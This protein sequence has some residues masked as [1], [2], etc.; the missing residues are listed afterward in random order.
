MPRKRERTTAKVAWTEEDLLHARTA[1]ESGMSK[2]LAARTYKIPF[3][4]LRD[5]LK[6]Q[7]IGRPRL[8]RKPVF[9]QQQESEIAEQVKLL[10]SIYYGLSVTDLRKS[11]YKYAEINSIKN[12]FDKNSKMAGLDWVQGFMRRN[13]SVAVRKAEA[14]SLNRVSAF[15]KEEITH[16]YQMLGDLMEKYRFPPNNIYNADKTGITT[17]TDPGKVLAE[18]G[19]R[20]VGAVT[21]GESGRNISV[22]CAMS[23]AG[24]FVPPMFIF[25]RQ[26]MTPLLEKDG[27]PGAFYTHSKNGWINEE[28]FV[29]WLKHFAAYVKPTE[30]SPVLVILD[31]HSSHISLPAFNYCKKNHIAMLSIP[32]HS[33]HR[34]QPLDVS[35]Y[36][37]LKAAYRHECN[38]HMKTHLM[39]KITPYDVACLFNKAYAQVANI[40]KGEAGFRATGIYPLNPN[41]FTEQDF[42]PASLMAQNSEQPTQNENETGD[43]LGA[44]QTHHMTINQAPASP[45]TGSSLDMSNHQDHESP[46]PDPLM[47]A[48]NQNLE[49]SVHAASKSQSIKNKSPNSGPSNQAL[50][51]E[52]KQTYVSFSKIVTTPP[53][54]ASTLKPAQRKRK[55]HS[56]I[57]T[58]T[59]MKNIL[60]EKETNKKKKLNK[61]GRK[62]Q[63]RSKVTGNNRNK[64]KSGTSCKRKVLQDSSSDDD[65]QIENVCDDDSD[66]ELSVEG[67]E[68]NKCNI[69]EEF[70]RN[71]EMWYRCTIC[72]FWTHAMC[73]GWDSPDGYICDFC[74]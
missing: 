21:S 58:S 49:A 47:E 6:N 24:N 73:T 19:Q 4:T 9:N 38:M 63:T 32:P 16:F 22:M 62:D 10:G 14:T 18:K 66:D 3:T 31:N 1:I 35:F 50:L 59:P 12:N 39:A 48:P 33:S 27:P 20:R 17:V 23:A 61:T 11:V 25:L 41:V 71:N 55:Q 5:R 54:I 40:S 15:N 7:N 53:T 56:T 67:N 34:T 57:L 68:Y 72:G 65:E 13:P 29:E 36:G 70:G 46:A 51:G 8:G 69:C 42:L 52:Q 45:V 60:E 30:D 2:R 26:R 43:N 44:A 64:N 37:P 28:L 74:N